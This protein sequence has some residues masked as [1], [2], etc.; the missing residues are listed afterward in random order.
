MKRYWLAAAI[1]ALS[2]SPAA[3]ASG[4]CLIE[5]SG[6]AVLNGP[7]RIDIGQGGNFTAG[8][9]V[10]F[11]QMVVEAPGQGTGYWNEEPGATHA[12][13]TLGPMVRRGAC[14]ENSEARVCAWR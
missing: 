11:A 9:N 8:N 12:H 2:V 10:Y 14:W 7:C 4:T 13:S 6:R 3:A 5:V 1:A